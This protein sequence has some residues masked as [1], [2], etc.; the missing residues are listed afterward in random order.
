MPK[1]T[2]LGHSAF[3]IESSKA[4]LIVDPFLSGNPLARMK[5]S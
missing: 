1:L 5:P 2:F 4:R 3:L